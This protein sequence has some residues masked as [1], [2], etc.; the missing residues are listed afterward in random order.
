M[1]LG[2]WRVC[3]AGYTWA[4][5]ATAFAASP[6]SAG[7][8]CP[9]GSSTETSCPAGT[10]NPYQKKATLTDCISCDPGSYWATA[11]LTAVT[12]Q[13]TAGYFCTLGST[14]ATPTSGVGGQ[15]QPG[16]Y[17]PAGATVALPCP[18]KQ[19][20]STAGLSAPQGNWLL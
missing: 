12:G 3:P 7:K 20:C 17:C 8:Y 14:T 10:Y 4:A 2:Y 6:C 11:G 16:Y 13:C 18:P 19:Y 9:A 1:H 5:G 15:C